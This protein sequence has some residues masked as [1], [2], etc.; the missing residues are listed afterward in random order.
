MRSFRLSITPKRRAAVRFVGQV[1]RSLQKALADN[2][3][4]NQAGIARALEVDRSVITKQLHGERDISLS[5]V[6]ELAWAMGLLPELVLHKRD[7]KAG[8]NHD[9]VPPASQNADVLSVFGTV[10]SQRKVIAMAA[11]EFIPTHEIVESSPKRETI[12]A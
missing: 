7:A 6:G 1:R 9:S 8:D 10:P 12:D 4:M 5:R 2:P 3:E 11:G